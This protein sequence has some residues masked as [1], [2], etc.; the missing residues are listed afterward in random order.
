MYKETL[1]LKI[2]FT[3]CIFILSPFLS[4]AQ[5][6]ADSVYA[7]ILL[8]ET[9]IRGERLQIPFSKL[10]R[11][12][13]ILDQKIIRELPVQSLS[14][15]LV[16]VTGL[17]VRQRGAW[18]G[19]ADIS[20]NGG[21]FDQTLV[22]LNGIKIIDSQTGHNMMNLPVSPAS[23]ER[24]E[25]IKGAAAGAYGINALNGAVNIITK[26]PDTNGF[27]VSFTTGSSFEKDTSNNKLYGLSG[28]DVGVSF[29]SKKTTNYLAYSTVQSSGYRYNTSINNHRLFFSNHANFKNGDEVRLFAGVVRNKFGANGFY[30][31]PGDIESAENVQ[32][33]LVSADGVFRPKEKWTIRP[34]VS[35][36]GNRDYYIYVRQN[37]ALYENKH[38]THSL[39]V[40]F[41]NS[42]QS[43]VGVFGIGAEYRSEWIQSNSLGKW[44]RDNYGIFAEYSYN[45]WY[46]FSLHAASYLNYSKHF[47]WKLLPSLDLG[48]QIS[49]Q[50]RIYANVGTGMRVPT[51]TDWYYTGPV[52]IGNSSLMP[53]HAFIVESGIKFNSK[54]LHLQTNYFYR[55]TDQFIDWVRD[56][57]NH[58]WQPENFQKVKVHGISLTAD[59]SISKA[60]ESKSFNAIVGIGYTYLKLK[61][62][63]DGEKKYQYSHYA[64]ENLTHQ[65]TGRLTLKFLEHYG[66]TVSGRMEQRIKSSPYFILDT[67]MSGRWK[68][69]QASVL[70]N[71][72]THT[73]YFDFNSAPLPG[74]WFSLSL[75]YQL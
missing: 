42:I 39:G 6:D 10:N 65:L 46:N 61:T 56:S 55:I 68:G 5:D 53:E 4:Y 23:I 63:E 58:P 59:Y 26:Q 36:R 47:G 12:I 49:P 44:H 3:L 33:G 28:A 60:T 48:Y 11:D 38:N 20:I 9:V 57:L 14:E 45:L 13:I 27:Y 71:N 15:L 31:P 34:S 51:Y 75:S 29:K 32:T 72:L 24:I 43:S 54:N 19:Q 41:N 8:E 1:L 17:D 74:R 64:L 21:T 18:G 40:S 30:A 37:P 7:E 73:T 50:W 69:F 16:F 70:L 35:Y 22:L 2:Y 62:V 25:I 67:K 66:I 52:N